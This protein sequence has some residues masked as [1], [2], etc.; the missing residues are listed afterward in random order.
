VSGR[1]VVFLKVVDVKAS[2]S[3]LAKPKNQEFT[4]GK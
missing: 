2:I 4:N 1:K 3:R